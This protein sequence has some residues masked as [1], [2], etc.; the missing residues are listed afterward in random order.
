MVTMSE[1]AWSVRRLRRHP[2]DVAAVVLSLGVGMALCVAVFSLTNTL[3]FNSTAGIR[4]RRTLIRLNWTNRGGP[5]TRSEFESFESQRPNVY[6]SVAAQGDLLLPAFLPSG[7]ATIS[8]AFVSRDFFRTLGT[9]PIRGRLLDGIR[10]DQAASVAVV[11]EGLWRGAFNGDEGILGRALTIGGRAFTIVGVTPASAP[12][13]RVV[14]LSSG[15][16]AYPQVWL[17]LADAVYWKAAD[18]RTRP[19]LTTAG[20]LSGTSSLAS[21]RAESALVARRLSALNGNP[22][23]DNALRRQ[24]SL[25]VFRGGL[26]WQDDPAESLLV[27]GVFL[28]VPLGVLGIGCVNVINLQLARAIDQASELSLRVALGASRSRIIGLLTMEVSLLAVLAGGTG[29]LGAHLL[30]SY[31]HSFSAAPLV[32]DGRVLVFAL[33]IVAIVI[34]TAGL[35]PAWLAS[36]D[37]ARAGLRVIGHSTPLRT[38]LRGLLVVLQVAA[39]L[40]LLSVSSLAIRS[41]LVRTPTLP[42]DAGT[43][44]LVDLDLTDVRR[45]EPRPGLFVTAVLD[46]LESQSGVVAA[47][48]SA[49]PTTTGN[50]LRYWPSTTGTH[51]QRVAFGGPVTARWFDATEVTF[52]AGR[53]PQRSTS[54]RVPI[55]INAALASTMAAP[56]ANPLGTELQVPDPVAPVVRPASIVGV[57]ANTQVGSDGRP[58]P[59]LFLPMLPDA[60]SALTLVARVREVTTGRQALEAAIRAADPLVPI[61]RIESLDDRTKE[62]SRWLRDATWLGVA[63]SVLALG[64]AAGGLHSLLSYVVGRRTREIGIRVALGARTVDVVGLVLKHGLGLVLVGA[65]AGLASAFALTTALRSVLFG[66]SMLHPSAL[67]PAVLALLFVSAAASAVPAYRAACVNPV[68]ALRHE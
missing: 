64:L 47:A 9:Q 17:P 2:G 5:F 34:A 26:Y 25:Q 6:T 41:L 54:P 1:L 58:V 56:G 28:L 51:D 66:M 61:G 31:A 52:L 30:L 32:I 67:L 29:W 35:L 23:A 10:S 27:I 19:W 20:R 63:I 42:A 53:P 33:V 37:V 48:F 21:A 40:V 62:L 38:R 14:D 11:S 22:E 13:L 57:V 8:V 50:P 43:I 60:P 68:E 55:V 12:G 24:A 36:R 65:G 18:D 16:H 15:E 39:S 59:M 44:L 46:R 4:D 45:T 49:F 7:P 3:V